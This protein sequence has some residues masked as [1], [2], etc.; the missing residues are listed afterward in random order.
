MKS[1]I[2]F[3]AVI[4]PFLTLLIGWQLGV[5]SNKLQV[6][7]AVKQLEE[8]FN[9]GSSLGTMYNPETEIDLKLFWTVWRKILQEYNDP[10]SLNAQDMLYGAVAGMVRATEDPYTEFM[11]PKQN[12]EF[13]DSLD[14]NLQ[15]IGAELTMKDSLLTVV[16]PIKGSPAAEAGLLP[17]D[18]IIE[19][20]GESTDGIALND[21]VRKIRGPEG[22]TVT[23]TILRE[24]EGDVREVPIVRAAI[25]VPST[26]YELKEL[27]DKKI[28]YIAI[29]QFGEHTVQ[30]VSDALD[31]FA[32]TKL[33]GMILDLRFNG[34]GYLDKSEE[35]VS[36][37]LAEGKAVSIKRRG[38]E[39]ETHFVTGRTK[40][41]TTP[42]VILI[43]EGSASASEIVAA[44]LTEQNR[45]ISMG[46][47]SFGK[48]SIQ[49]VFPMPGGS[50]LRLTVAKW[51][52]PNDVNVSEVGITPTYTVE[53]SIEQM[54][55]DID[56]Q[57]DAAMEY[58]VFGKKPPQ[59]V[60][61][62]SSSSS[63]DTEA[64]E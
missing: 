13:K 9:S 19:V 55:N 4:V 6:E 41:A 1:I 33:S 28:G 31:S 39:D 46:V 57:F 43:N 49:E 25:T 40:D 58:L 35:I 38:E 50:S 45:A 29:N 12:T 47:T 5:N 60:V 63:S 51:Y 7:N 11:T 8:E 24:G 59:P 48:G 27:G 17:N 18:I 26:E 56:P 16:A 61:S 54:Q 3:I 22:T 2:K 53:Q 21:L 10:E 30:E 20:D 23:L 14:G 64:A 42:M 15:G 52:T 36:M 37:F 62:S 44:A 32:N 34:G